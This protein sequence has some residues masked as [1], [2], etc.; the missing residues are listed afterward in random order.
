MSS[1]ERPSLQSRI[2][3]AALIGATNAIV[4]LVLPSILLDRISQSYAFPLTFSEIY[5]IGAIII[6][7]QV[8]AALTRGSAPAAMLNA[9]TYIVEIY[10]IYTATGGGYLTVTSG[11]TVELYFPT[12][13]LLFLLYPLFSI[14]KLGLTFLLEESEGSKPT[15]DEVRG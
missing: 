5:G 7:L 4:W 3:T 6:G 9:G 2:A 12:L 10:Y 14:A 11:V 1:G 13:V 15:R 8:L